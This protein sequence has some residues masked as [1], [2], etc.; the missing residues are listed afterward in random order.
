MNP[1]QRLLYDHLRD[2]GFE[3]VPESRFTLRWLT[4]ARS[5]VDVLHLHWPEGL[6]TFQRGPA[7]LRPLGSRAKLVLFAVRLGYARALGY[8]IAWT[9]HQVY[10]H[11]SPG[12]GVDRL[13]ALVLARAAHVLIVHDETTR[14]HVAAA[15]GP[16]TAARLA[17]VPHGSYVGVYPPGR[18]RA[19]LRRELDLDDAAFVF[20]CF[21]ELRAHKSWRLVVRAFRATAP[22]GSALVL[23]GMVRSATVRNAILAETAG[24]PRIRLLLRFV[25]DAEVAELFGAADAAVVPRDD[26]GTSGSLLL[27]LSLGVPV[28]VADRPTYRDVAGNGDAGW[29]FTPGDERSL[30]A[31]LE[32][33]AAD[34]RGAQR[35]GAAALQCALRLR[36]PDVAARTAR[37]L[38]GAGA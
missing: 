27:P 12:R 15:L 30:R 36:W 34:P 19:E 6:Y 26:G 28:V 31:A 22:S 23:A 13:G 24:D 17:I 35:R 8:R 32:R 14:D 11:G 2:E 1:Y 5:R 38:R 33:A 7:V 25:D 4:D 10:P 9:V 37:V 20:L 18:S 21:G 3:L 29:L 16:G